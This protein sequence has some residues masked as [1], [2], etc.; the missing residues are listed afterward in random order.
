VSLAK[1][2]Q[3]IECIVHLTFEKM[4]SQENSNMEKKGEIFNI[5]EKRKE[6]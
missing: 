5:E 6:I 3:L 4:S 2:T 1:F